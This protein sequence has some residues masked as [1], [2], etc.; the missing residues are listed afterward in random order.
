MK[1]LIF[2]GLTEKTHL[3]KKKRKG[4]T[5][6]LFKSTPVWLL[7]D[8]HGTKYNQTAW[9]SFYIQYLIFTGATI[10]L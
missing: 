8:C 4:G 6:V 5:H 1:I 3:L 9:P 10:S 7:Y 2:L